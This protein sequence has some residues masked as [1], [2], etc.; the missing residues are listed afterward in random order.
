M[1]KLMVGLSV[2]L[3][4]LVTTSIVLAHQAVGSIPRALGTLWTCSKM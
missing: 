2:M 4:M 3:L 1:R